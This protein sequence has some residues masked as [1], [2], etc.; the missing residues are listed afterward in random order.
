MQHRSIDAQALETGEI[1]TE[2]NVTEQ[3]Q[4]DLYCD[5]AGEQA[6]IAI[7]NMSKRMT[8]K[9]RKIISSSK[10]R[11]LGIDLSSSLA[12]LGQLY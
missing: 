5:S 2:D 6:V 7:D 1:D 10:S 3:R 11:S 12:A 8:D 9:R 4:A